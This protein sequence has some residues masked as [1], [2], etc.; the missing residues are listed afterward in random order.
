MFEFSV[1]QECLDVKDSEKI[2]AAKTGA[3]VAE[4]EDAEDRCFM[5]NGWTSS[6][7]HP[8]SAGPKCFYK[9]GVSFSYSPISTLFA[10]FHYK[11]SQ[12]SP[13]I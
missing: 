13:Q 12:L 5:N 10:W 7:N 2:Q 6:P 8:L 4:C 1:P 9:K 3:T 11:W